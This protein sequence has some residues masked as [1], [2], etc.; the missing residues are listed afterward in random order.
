MLH[1]LTGY[2]SGDRDVFSSFGNLVDLINID[3]SFFSPLDVIVCRLDQLQKHVFD[4]F[5]DI[6]GFCQCRGVSDREGN[7]QDFG[8][9]P[10]QIG[11]SGTCRTDH[12]DIALL[13]V[14]TRITQVVDSLVVVV[15]SHCD[16]SFGS[17]LSDHVLI[18]EFHDLTRLFQIS[19]QDSGLLFLLFSLSEAG[20]NIVGRLDAVL[21]DD[22]A[23]ASDET[24]IC[25]R[26][27]FSAEQALLVFISHFRLLSTYVCRP[28]RQAGQQISMIF[29][30]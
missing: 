26:F 11:L 5:A 28:A 7:T 8:Q 18:Q 24:L 30:D 21:T 4:I 17:V 23:S 12:Q 10:G 20:Q 6:T 14:N 16:G 9:R 19:I 27:R 15:N 29:C 25:L 22:S 2:I 3:D 13:K 1:A